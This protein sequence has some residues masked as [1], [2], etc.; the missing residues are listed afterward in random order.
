MARRRTRRSTRAG[1]AARRKA[2]KSCGRGKIKV[3]GY[4]YSRS[5]S[6]KT[7]RVPAYCRRR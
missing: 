6:R 7:I 2:A 5:G 4:S 1:S 3:R